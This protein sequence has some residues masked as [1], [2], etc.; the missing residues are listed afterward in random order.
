MAPDENTLVMLAVTRCDEFLQ[1]SSKNQD[2]PPNQT[3]TGE[4]RRNE[5]SPGDIYQVRQAAD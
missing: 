3:V 1:T 2:F 5:G 4:I